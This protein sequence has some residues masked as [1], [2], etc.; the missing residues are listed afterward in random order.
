MSEEL[1]TQDELPGM[2]PVGEK[3]RQARK[4][5][6]LEIEDIATK[7]RIPKR[8]LENLERAEWDKLPAPT[9]TMGFAKSYATEVGLDREEI[10]AELR[11]QMAGLPPAPVEDGYEV[12]DP[13]RSFPRWLIWLALVALVVAAGWFI[14]SNERALGDDDGED[15]ELLLDPAADEA[16]QTAEQVLLTANRPVDVR[17]TDGDTVLYEAS[18]TPGQSYTVPADAAAP[19]LAVSDAGALRIA[20][21]TADAPALGPDG[22]SL[23]NVSLL[24]PALLAGPATATPPPA[25]TAAT[26]T[27]AASRPTAARQPAPRPATRPAASR[28]ANNPTEND[29]DTPVQFD[30]DAPPPPP[31]Q[32]S[33]A[34]TGDAD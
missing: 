28:P 5:K 10:A 32:T 27:P 13:A 3:L 23:S 25:T 15:Q 11:E 29:G 1:D 26:P 4:A 16:A 34:D 6:G 33:P 14:Y 8:H 24:G 7:T 17:I 31:I 30:T 18:L 2:V 21:G 9:Y 20:V 12:A 19:M 22:Q